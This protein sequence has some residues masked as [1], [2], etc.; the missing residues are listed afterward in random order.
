MDS[1]SSMWIQNGSRLRTFP[2]L[3]VF[4]P[5]EP[6]NKLKEFLGVRRIVAAE[7]TLDRQGFHIR[8]LSV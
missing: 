3:T 8:T 6:L 1:E 4:N 5:F 2:W 7:P